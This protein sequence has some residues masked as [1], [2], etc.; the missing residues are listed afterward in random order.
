MGDAPFE[1]AGEGIADGR[2]EL[3]AVQFP[4]RFVQLHGR[5]RRRASNTHLILLRVNRR[6]MPMPTSTA[7]EKERF[8]AAIMAELPHFLYF[9]QNWSI[10]AELVCPRFGVTHFHH[11]ELLA[12][13]ESTAPEYR[14]LTLIDQLLMSDRN[15]CDGRGFEGTA[16][17]LEQQLRQV[18]ALRY[19]VD[20]LLSYS[21]ACGVYLG[22][23][24]GKTGSR[25]TSRTVKGTT[26]WTINHPELPVAG[27]TS[28]LVPIP[29]NPLIGGLAPSCPV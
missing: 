17:R 11:P 6:E 25:V 18:D 8:W 3:G 24:A 16:E 12:A 7:E 10:P 2:G 9:L 23:L 15:Y 4:E 5:G 14:L 29:G 20:R 13:L 22:R 26:V 1:V 21:T 19:Q 27:Q 28:G